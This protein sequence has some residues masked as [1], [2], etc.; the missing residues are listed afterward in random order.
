ML[1]FKSLIAIAAI[2]ATASAAQAGNASGRRHVKQP[3]IFSNER[4][5]D[6]HAEMPPATPTWS[7]Q[8]TRGLSAPAGR[9]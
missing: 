8:G 7:Y 1:G 2:A 6:G 3:A 9:S 5:R 4:V